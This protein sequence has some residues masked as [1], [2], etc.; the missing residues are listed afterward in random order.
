MRGPT[1]LLVGAV[2]GVPVAL[3]LSQP[4]LVGVA[5]VAALVPDLDASEATLKH[6]SFTVGHRRSRRRIKPFYTLA[7]FIGLI[8][9]HRGWLHSLYG[10]IIFSLLLGVT[11]SLVVS[12]S[13]TVSGLLAGL[14]FGLAGF[15]GYLSHLFL[16]A[17]TP[18]GIMFLGNHKW[19]LVSERFRLPTGSPWEHLI[20]ALAA[21]LVLFYLISNLGSW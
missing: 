18:A 8:F 20:S 10:A 19:H 2:A 15:S 17:L 4:F 12:W 5:L 21:V 7:N 6:W 3:V 14:S 9:K 11:A 16:D 13:T 1:H